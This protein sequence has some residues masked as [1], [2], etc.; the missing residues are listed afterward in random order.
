LRNPAPFRVGRGPSDSGYLEGS[1]DFVR[2]A[3][4][5][6]RDAE[7]TIEELYQWQFDGPF[8]RDFNGVSAR[9]ARRDVGAVEH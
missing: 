2:V 9:G 6:L 3:R 7:T 4:G 5:T 8:L 1:L